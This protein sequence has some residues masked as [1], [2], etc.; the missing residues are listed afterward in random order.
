MNANPGEI[1]GR[2]PRK[3]FD[4][5][6]NEISDELRTTIGE[7]SK[8]LREFPDSNNPFKEGIL[9]NHLGTSPFSMLF[10]MYKNM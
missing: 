1:I 4:L 3:S 2:D 10:T 6:S 9:H 7:P 8:L 5:R